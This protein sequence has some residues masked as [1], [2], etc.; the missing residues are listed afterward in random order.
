MTN[1]PRL[2]EVIREMLERLLLD[3]ITR[4]VPDDEGVD[5]LTGAYWI[6]HRASTYTDVNY[7]LP[8]SHRRLGEGGSQDITFAPHGGVMVITMVGQ[9]QSVG[10]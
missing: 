5:I 3:E 7:E 6:G 4:H 1:V 8:F 9:F 10:R 2:T